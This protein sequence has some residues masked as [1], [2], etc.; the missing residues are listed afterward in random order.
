MNN[1]GIKEDEIFQIHKI[2]GY[3]ENN[4]MIKEIL[5]QLNEIKILDPSCG[6]GVFLITIANVLFELTTFLNNKM[7]TIKEDFLPYKGV[8][9]RLSSEV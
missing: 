1:Y 7:M 9:I 3:E 5:Y 8:I 4:Q 2:L 6:T